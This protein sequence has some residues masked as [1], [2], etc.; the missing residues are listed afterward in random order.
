MVFELAS[1]VGI[2]LFGGEAALSAEEVVVSEEEP[3]EEEVQPERRLLKSREEK[4]G[5]RSHVVVSFLYPIYFGSAIDIID[6]QHDIDYFGFDWWT[7]A[8]GVDLHF[9]QV[10]LKYFYASAS[11]SYIIQTF[12][13]ELL[14]ESYN[15]FDTVDIKAHIGGIFSPF[16]NFQVY[17]GVGAGYLM[18]TLGDYWIAEY[19]SDSGLAISVAAG[20]DYILMR[21]ISIGLRISTTIVP[22]LS[23][24]EIFVDNENIGCFGIQFGAGLSY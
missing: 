18:Q 13:S 23:N 20:A 3:V 15:D 22:S 5:P 19:S 7:T 24:W 1:K 14:A 12:S 10:F 8:Y 2:Q 4:T 17:G 11:L 6:V 9:L 16:K 21:F